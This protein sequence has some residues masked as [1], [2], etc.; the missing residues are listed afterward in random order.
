MIATLNTI[1]ELSIR[2]PESY[3]VHF[4]TENWGTNDVSYESSSTPELYLSMDVMEERYRMENEL[5]EAI[6]RGDRRNALKSFHA[7][8]CTRFENR[9][10]DLLRDAK[11]RL[12]ILNTLCRKAAEKSF[13]HPIYLN[14][15][16]TSYALQ[17]EDS[18]SVENLNALML[19]M[20]RRYCLLVQ[21]QSMMNYSPVIRK[22]LNYIHLICIIHSH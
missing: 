12:V 21:N 22:A 14:E 19:D 7:F 10:K 11:N 13:V 9:T 20:I 8:S 17:I 2:R 1:G 4:I 3:L 18:S 5:L 16:S 15:I 6:S